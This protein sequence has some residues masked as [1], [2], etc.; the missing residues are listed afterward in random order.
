MK[1]VLAS[2]MLARA[3]E[4]KASATTKR[5]NLA[6]QGG[7]A[8]GAFT[9]GVLDQILG[10]ERITIEGIS[11][12]SA[13]AVNA[14]M[15]AD[16]LCR[17]GREEAQKRLAD[18]WRSAS[19]TGN[20]PALQR[21]VMERL[22]SFTPLEGTPV[23]AW[24]NALSRYFS[25][26]DVNP[27]N[28][29][30][31]K[32]LIERFVDFEIL[33]ANTELP[34][35]ISATNVQ[36]GHVRIFPRDK[37]TADAVMASACLPLLFRAVEIDGVPYWDGGFLGNPVI[38][39]FFRTT[40]TEDVLVVQINPLVRQATPTSSSEIMNRINEITFNSSLLA[41]YRAIDFV[42][43]LID[44][45]RLP[46]GIGPGEYRRINVHRI[47]LDRFGTH[48]DTFSR[49]STDYDFFEMLRVSGKRAARR[50]L[51]EHF[52]DIGVRSTV[53]LRAEAQAEWA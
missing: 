12:T 49:L 29:N 47:V 34:L 5:I 1:N 8:H 15:L 52:D 7:G 45:G 32:D 21:A 24:V 23:Q 10:D 43:R 50:F 31:L 16:G 30:P 39:P 14:V 41:E 3:A 27:L 35:F 6:L 19:S 36:T 42:A 28:I 44:Q 20:L 38:F 33:R 2:L 51:D 4:K 48:L 13:G 18:F 40:A 53:D 46:R 26:Y 9:W 11:G 37:I 25:P 22:L 17:G